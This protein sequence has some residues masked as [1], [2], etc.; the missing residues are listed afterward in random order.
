M[1][2]GLL[3]VLGQ[4]AFFRRRDTLRRVVAARSAFFGAADR[5]ARSG[6]QTGQ[7]FSPRYLCPREHLFQPPR[8]AFGIRSPRR[9]VTPARRSGPAL[10]SAAHTSHASATATATSAVRPSGA[11]EHTWAR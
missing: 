6:C 3:G 9:R 1:R 11:S 8:F 4:T 10:A 5:C 2:S 7:K